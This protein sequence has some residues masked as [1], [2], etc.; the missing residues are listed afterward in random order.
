M[1]KHLV[2]FFL[3]VVNAQLVSAQ[4]ECLCEKNFITIYQKIKDNYI[5]W[6]D[7]ITPKN[8]AEFDKLSIRVQERSKKIND[9]AECYKVLSEWTSFFKDAHLFINTQNSLPEPVESAEVLKNRAGKLS[10]VKFDSEDSFLAE[11]NAKGPKLEEIEGVWESDDQVY[12]IGIKR[13]S[14]KSIV[15][16]LLKKR[17]D[18]WV[19]GKTKFVLEYISPNRYK[20]T[21]YYADFSSEQFLGRL[22]K[23]VFV[24]DG[25]YKFNK[26][27]PS[28][29][30]LISNKEIIQSLPEYRVEKLDSVTTLIVLPPFTLADAYQYASQMI[31]GNRSLI[32]AT[33]HLIIDLRN[34]P[35]GD[36]NVMS[37]LWPYISDGQ[38]LRKGGYFKASQEN[39][40]LLDQE[41]KS[42][43]SFPMYRELFNEKLTEVTKRM[44]GNM[45]QIIQGPDK[46]YN[47]GVVRKKPEKVAILVNKNTASFAESVTLEAKQSKKTIVFGENSKGMADYIDVRDWGLP[48]FGW[49][50]AYGMARS[51]RLPEN[52]IDN[53]GLSP[54]VKIP[55]DEFDW[56]E[57]TRKYLHDL[58]P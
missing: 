31:I 45:G 16:F 14:K 19:A 34:N 9:A 8:K 6:D 4:N 57:Y 40:I 49:R 30:E 38:I 13:E 54:D 25:V 43:Q 58:N 22:I 56:V 42:I 47:D 55:K 51:G 39:L 32:D 41:L 44:R 27:S 53:V 52:P 3:F 2:L 11:L 10:V 48:C 17:D 33:K 18:L 20:T 24:I 36:E 7:K 29:K 5:G 35:G 37:P 12:R 26:I 1:K 15:G 23:N 50:I 28:P 21:Y 46:I